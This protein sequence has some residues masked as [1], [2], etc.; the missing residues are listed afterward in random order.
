MFHHWVTH[1]F[2]KNMGFLGECDKEKN[3][4]SSGDKWQNGGGVHWVT[5]ASNLIGTSKHLVAMLYHFCIV[6]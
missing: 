4:G 1:E 5:V 6:H 2:K 3:M